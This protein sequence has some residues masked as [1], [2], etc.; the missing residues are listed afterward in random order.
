MDKT[1]FFKDIVDNRCNIS[2][3][4]QQRQRLLAAGQL[5][6]LLEAMPHT[7]M[8]LNRSMQM[9]WANQTLFATIFR[10][11]SD[12]FMGLRP[13]EIFKCVNAMTSKHGCGTTPQCHICGSLLTIFKSLNGNGSQE[14]C[15]LL[16]TDN[17]AYNLRVKARLIK[18]EEDV[19]NAVSVVDISDAK[20]K[21]MLERLF[22]HDIM[23]LA[24]SIQGFTDLL[25][26]SKPQ[27]RINQSEILAILSATAGDL[28]ELVKSQKDLLSAEHNELSVYHKEIKVKELLGSV[29][30]LFERDDLGLGRKIEIQNIDPDIIFVSDER[31]LKRIIVNSVKN[32]L[33]AIEEGSRVQVR[34]KAE[35]NFVL[36]EVH[37]DCYI[38]KEI[39]GS[40]FRK[41]FS[42]KNKDRGLGTYSIKLLTEKYLQGNVW[43]VST[44]EQGTTFYIQIPDGRFTE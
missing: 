34:C 2:D 26:T 43:F 40:I 29:Q 33:E 35:G 42:T 7:V 8:I 41:S 38:P 15:M 12:E 22:F 21:R 36:F 9:V 13:G 14:E 44:K 11:N 30:R 20:N 5:T 1:E 6:S 25:I 23:N 19:F 4:R 28:I 24:G 37:N 10:E 27:D 32:A 18:I 39:Q 3:I 17:Q 16:T 31:L